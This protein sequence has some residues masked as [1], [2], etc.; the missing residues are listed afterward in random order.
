MKMVFCVSV[1]VCVYVCVCVCVCACVCVCLCVCVVCVCV[2]VCVQ[3]ACMIVCARMCACEIQ[4]KKGEES[5]QE[6]I[7]DQKIE[8]VKKICVSGAKNL[9]IF[10]G[11]CGPRTPC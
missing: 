10:S 2:C 6:T 9:K 1:C 11:A 3:C 4:R 5:N 7:F 8:V